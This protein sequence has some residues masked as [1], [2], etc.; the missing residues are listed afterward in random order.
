MRRW[1]AKLPERLLGG[2][3]DDEAGVSFLSVP[4]RREAA[5]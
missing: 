1:A 4:R 3:A 5:Q 2:V